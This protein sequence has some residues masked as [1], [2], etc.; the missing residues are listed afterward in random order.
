MLFQATPVSIQYI[1]KPGDR[2]IGFLIV[3]GLDSVTESSGFLLWISF[4]H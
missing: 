4:I 2:V 3:D 1:S